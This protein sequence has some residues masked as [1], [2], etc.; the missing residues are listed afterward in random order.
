MSNVTIHDL[1]AI[2]ALVD[3]DEA[4]VWDVSAAVTRRATIAQIRGSAA[5]TNAQNVFTAQQIVS[6]ASIGDDGVVINLPA[7]SVTNAALTVTNGGVTR[8]AMYARDAQSNL[9]LATCDLGVDVAGPLLLVGRNSNATGPASGTIR[10]VDRSGSN[11]FLWSDDTGVMR[12]HSAAPTTL[13]SDTAGT[14]V[15]TQTS[16][17]AAKNLLGEVGD[18]IEAIRA[19]IE[20]AKSGLRRFTY[21][22]G[23]FGNEEFAGV[24]TDFAPRYGMDR[25]ES[26][27]AGK[28]LNEIQLF[29][30]LIR[31]VAYLAEKLGVE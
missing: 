28:S 11:L 30:D 26:H 6:P 2:S 23:T 12:V 4:A 15:G 19:I 27:P 21:K 13:A 18:P 14:V 5:V 22:T 25:D 1:A 17:A 10:F 9:I 16:M 3:T 20:A 24:V 7:G 29:G 31:S 8:L